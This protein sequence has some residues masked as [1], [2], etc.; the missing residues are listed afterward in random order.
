[1]REK[2]T[3][4]GFLMILMQRLVASSTSAIRTTLERRLEA[5][6]AP[7][8]QLSLFPFMS[9]DEW[10]DLDGQEQVDTLLGTRLK[11]LKNERAEVRL[12]LEAAQVCERAGPD[13]KAEALLEWIYRLQQEEGDP[14]L[15]ILVFTEFVPTQAMLRDFLTDRGFSVTCLNG[16][17]DMDERRRAQEEFAEKARMLVS[18]DAGGEGLNLQFCHAVVN[19]DIPWNPMRI[20]Q[21]IGR[22]DRIGQTHA[23][24][25]VNLLFEE[26]VEFRVREVLEEKLAVILHEFGVDKASDVLDSAQ[27][28]QI[29]ERLYV[30]AI[31][32]PAEVVEKVD[33]VIDRIR[34]Q[35]EVVKESVCVLGPSDDLSPGEAQRLMAHPLPHWVERMTVSYLQ[36]TCGAA[37]RRGMAWDLVWPNGQTDTNVVFTIK[38]LEETPTAQH[39]TLDNSRVRGLAMRLPHFAPGQPILRLALPDLP[40]DL[41]G[42][43]SLWRIKIHS[44]ERNRW[45]IFPLFL[46]DD[47]RCLTPAARHVWDQLLTASP[48]IRGHVMGEAAKHAFA[49]TRETAE[50]QGR[51][52]YDELL[53]A[54]H[55]RLSRERDKGEY[56]FDSRR[57]VIG[58]IGL[59]AV[60]AHRLAQIKEE[61]RHWRDRLQREAQVT[62]EMTP[63]IIVHL[64]GGTPRA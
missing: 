22:V 39:L 46:H 49:K 1:M 17:M 42:Y 4:V 63:L 27:G 11:A 41:S 60:R 8:E 10:A 15:K 59:P 23:V 51:P 21:R 35:A 14:D 37:A 13:T 48:D 56:A 36:S 5:L 20:E 52:I 32:H 57:I 53:R 54:H 31:L 9:D 12:L 24:R 43:W 58:R 7:E 6:Q 55:A 16:S 38:D 47:G 34:E 29:F 26:T 2:R 3:H 44:D 33:S 61:E 62:P 64:E 19:Y 28:G 25:A 18:T 40:A 30:D 50:S 45:R